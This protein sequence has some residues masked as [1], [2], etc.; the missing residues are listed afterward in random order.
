MHSTEEMWCKGVIGRGGERVIFQLGIAAIAET[1]PCFGRGFR[2]F[3]SSS[4][5]YTNLLRRRQPA[6]VLS[7]RDKLLV[8]TIGAL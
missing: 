7:S 2:G 6:A 3:R 1:G 5:R 4:R 8:A